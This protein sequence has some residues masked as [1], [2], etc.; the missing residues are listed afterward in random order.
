MFLGEEVEL[1]FAT[2]VDNSGVCWCCE[3]RRSGA[4]MVVVLF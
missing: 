2:M 4:A 1:F 3:G